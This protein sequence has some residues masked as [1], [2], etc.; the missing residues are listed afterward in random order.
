MN[1]KVYLVLF[2]GLGNQL[3]QLANALDIAG[4]KE[5]I[6][7]ARLGNPRIQKNG[8]LELQEFNLPNNVKIDYQLATKTLTKLLS[9]L[10]SRNLSQLNLIRKCKIRAIKMTA[11][12]LASIKLRKRIHISISRNIGYSEN[13]DKTTNMPIGYFQSIKGL[14]SSTITAMKRMKIQS[15]SKIQKIM[16]EKY[17]LDNA[18]VLH[19]RMGDYRNESKIGMLKQEY[20]INALD[21]FSCEENNRHIMLFSDEFDSAIRYIPDKFKDR[22]IKVNSNG[23]NSAE[24]LEQMR[25]GKDYIISNSTFSWWAAFMSYSKNPCVIA[26]EPWFVSGVDVSYIIPDNWDTIPR[27]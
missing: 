6:I 27:K 7:L 24:V 23:L 4:D 19:I 14:S 21:Q 17:V 3:F 13:F 25:Y 18:L 20:F 9:Y 11:E 2:G 8:N 15:H 10:L 1:Q 12:I 22:I 5:I 16:N 26:P